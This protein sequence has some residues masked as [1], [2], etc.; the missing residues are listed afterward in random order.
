MTDGCGLANA[1][2]FHTLKMIYGWTHVPTAVQM[3]INGAKVGQHAYFYPSLAYSIA[4]GLLVLHPDHRAATRDVAAR[5]PVVWLRDSQMKIKYP[6]SKS[7]AVDPTFYTL[8]VLRHSHMSSPAHLSIET[9]INLAENGVPCATFAELIREDLA[10]R[11]DRLTTW[12]TMPELWAAVCREGGV[13]AQRQ[14]RRAAG[15]ARSKGFIFEDR[16]ELS[17]DDDDYDEDD[18]QDRILNDSSTAW[19]PDNVSGCPS[20]LEETV[21]SLLAA[22]F[23]PDR[24]GVLRAK[25]EAVAKRGMHT[26]QKKCRIAV[27]MSCSAFVI[28]GRRNLQRSSSGLTKRCLVDPVGVLEPGEVQIKSADRNLLC[29]DG[30]FSDA[31]LGDVLVCAVFALIFAGQ[32]D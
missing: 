14:A 26:V 16:E 6:E 15:A 2:L 19:C 18:V 4:Q 20:T 3:R 13:I 9:V 12:T 10:Q 24:S 28:P 31:I 17:D 11:I 29:Q 32:V 22:G 25:A 30:A 27:D 23:H 1:D 7:A 5:K 8:D 21:L